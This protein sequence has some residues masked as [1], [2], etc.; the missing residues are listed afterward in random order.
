[1]NEKEKPRYECDYLSTPPKLDC[2]IETVYGCNA[3]F[4]NAPDPFEGKPCSKGHAYWDKFNNLCRQ[5]K[6]K[7]KKSGGPF[8]RLGEG[9]FV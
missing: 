3:C 5:P 6:P 7:E 9:R 4:S 2:D 8:A 1:M